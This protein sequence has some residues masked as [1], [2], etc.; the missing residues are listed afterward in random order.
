MVSEQAYF[1]VYFFIIGDC[2]T[3][4]TRTPQNFRR[5]EAEAGAKP[6]STRSLTVKTRPQ[7]LRRNIPT[8]WEVH[9]VT[10]IL[11]EP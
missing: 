6:E 10:E 8:I 5:I 11:F 2:H 9:P 7:S 1:P 3:P 4:V